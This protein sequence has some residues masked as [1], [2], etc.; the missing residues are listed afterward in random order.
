M[1]KSWESGRGEGMGERYLKK[2]LPRC[3][4]FDKRC[5]FI[6]SRISLNSK[7]D[8]YDEEYTKEYTIITKLT[9]TKNKDKILKQPE[10][11]DT[12]WQMHNNLN[13][14]LLFR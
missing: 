7:D 8:K 14:N 2:Y 9:K 11:N 4:N 12:L 6:N 1:D 5:T 10:I 3:L 13:G